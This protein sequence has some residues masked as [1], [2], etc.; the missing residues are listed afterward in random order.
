MK[1]LNEQK[2]CF[3]GQDALQAFCESLGKKLQESRKL[4]YKT[5]FQNLPISIEN[6]K[7]SI[8]KGVDPDGSPWEV[9]MRF[10]YGYIRGTEGADGDSVDVFVGPDENAPFAYV[11]HC[12]DVET[13][14]FDEDKI[15][16]GFNSSKRAKE[17]F[18][19]HYDDPKFFG[20]INAI[21]MW[22]FSDKVFVK[23][24]TLK[25]LVASV[26][27]NSIPEHSGATGLDQSMKKTIL[28]HHQDQMLNP[29][30]REGASLQVPQDMLEIMSGQAPPIEQASKAGIREHGV[31][32]MKWGHRKQRPQQ[33]QVF[34]PK[35]KPPAPRQRNQKQASDLAKDPRTLSMMQVVH[36]SQA[37]LDAISQ[38]QKQR[39]AQGGKQ[40]SEHNHAEALEKLKEIGWLVLSSA[41]K[42]AGLG[43]A[44]GLLKTIVQ[45]PHGQ[46]MSLK[47]DSHGHH[48]SGAKRHKASRAFESR[49]G[50]F[51]QESSRGVYYAREIGRYGTDAEDRDLETIRESFPGDRVSFARTKRHAD[52]GMGYFHEKVDRAKAVV[53]KPTR[54]NRL[55]A[56]VFSEARH[57]IKNKIPVY[58]LRKGRLRRVKNVEA[59]S[60]PNQQGHF[61]RIIYRRRKHK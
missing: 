49:L 55:T 48:L 38:Q 34:Q 2:K 50:S 26:R 53:I 4:H 19:Q 20:G 59:L 36:R 21:P 31:K 23:K 35:Q 14:S 5:S 7:G 51:L 27:D 17:V 1:Y 37:E 32:G 43:E 41:L 47:S 24:H 39:A 61:G 18:L 11:V 54:K 40:T 22:K 9:K 60:S 44:A 57:A 46:K 16:L 3:T 58:A 25:K 8:R 56:G 12:N 52:L 6:R 28:G 10:P 45:S 29:E 33:K 15:F 42:V 13:N 30:V